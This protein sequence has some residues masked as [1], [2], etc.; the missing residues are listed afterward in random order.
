M[1][2]NISYGFHLSV[3]L[4]LSVITNDFK[5]EFQDECSILFPISQ[6]DWGWKGILGP[7]GPTPLLKRSHLQHIAR[8]HIQ[9]AFKDPQVGRLHSLSG[10]PMA[11]MA[12][13]TIKNVFPKMHIGTFCVLVCACRL[14]SS[15]W[16]PPEEPMDSVFLTDAL[17]LFICT[18]KIPLNFF[19]PGLKS[20]I[21]LGFSSYERCSSL[22]ISF[23]AL[24][25]ILH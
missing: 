14:C 18:D 23:M 8:D 11:V 13:L 15:H 12:T 25:C 22:I 3:R 9:V 17:H 6:I 19:F 5:W 4:E 20:P 10:Q 21:S 1:V 16:I 24:H 2:F 7:S